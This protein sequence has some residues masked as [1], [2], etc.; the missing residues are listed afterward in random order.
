LRPRDGSLGVAFGCGDLLG[1]FGLGLRELVA[2]ALGVLNGLCLRGGGLSDARRDAGRADESEL[3][4][5]DADGLHLLLNESLDL[6]E[7]LGLLFAVDL[8]DA[9]G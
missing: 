4:D 9:V 2:G 8:L 1:G 5:H 6:V 7:E 3:L